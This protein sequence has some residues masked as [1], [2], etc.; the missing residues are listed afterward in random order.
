MPR[1]P[2]TVSN[3][4][5][6]PSSGKRSANGVSIDIT[7]GPSDPP[8]VQAG[9]GFLEWRLPVSAL[10]EPPVDN[11]DGSRYVFDLESIVSD[12]PFSSSVWDAAGVAEIALVLP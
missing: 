9:A 2:A 6:L 1:P 12:Q 4:C 3:P 7:P 10:G 11:P 8:L 5:T